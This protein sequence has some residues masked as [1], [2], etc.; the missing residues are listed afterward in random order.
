MLRIRKEQIVVFEQVALRVFED[1]M[2]MHSKAFSPRLCEVLGDEQLRVALRRAINRAS[3]Y[4]FTCRGPIRL[5]TE[6]MF[7]YGSGFDTDPQ[8]SAVSDALNASGDQIQRAERIY[9]S[10]LDYLERVA[11]PDNEN[12]RKALHAVSVFARGPVPISG[13]ALVPE[14]I[15]QLTRAFPEKAAYVG[16]ERLSALIHEGRAEARRHGFVTIRGEVLVVV[17]MFAFGHGCTDDPLYPWIARTLT[18]QRIAGPEARAQRL[19]AKAVT[20]LN[21]VL[22]RPPNGTQK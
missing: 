5:Y 19:E 6:L 15:R 7:L 21:H 2:V 4:G 22:A 20:W 10:V 9:E 18:D 11:G 13:N 17:L 16:E 8:Y 12:V 3:A 14:M 1:E